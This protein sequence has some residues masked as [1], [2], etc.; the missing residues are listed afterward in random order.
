MISEIGEGGMGRVYKALDRN[1]GRL[2]AVK[3]LR[4]PDPFE[5]SR[6]RG[7]AEMI[8]LLDHPNIVKIFAIDTTPDCRP[9]IALEFAEGG[10]LDRE[11]NAQPLEPR[12]AAEM[13]EILARAIH[14]AHEKGVIHRDLKPANVLRGKDGVLKITDFG[15]AKQLEVSSGMTPSGAVMG[16][17]SYMAP[18]QAEGKV[19]QLGPPTDVYG[20]GAI[21]YEML[22][23]RP[24][25]RGVN[26]VD[27]LEQVRWAE[28]ASP[29][30]FVP[31]LHRDLA[32]ICLKCLRKTP[33]QRYATA[34]ALAEDLRHWLNGETIVARSAPS[35][36][37]AWR[38]IKRRPWQ[39][40]TTVATAFVAGLLVFGAIYFHNRQQ[41]EEYE[42]TLREQETSAQTERNELEKAAREKLDQVQNQ[43]VARLRERNE[44]ALLALEGI[45]DMILKGNL[46]N[47]KELNPLKAGLFKYYKEL[48]KQLK[49]E[50][51]DKKKLAQAWVE[52]GTMIHETGSKENA[53]EA[54]K[55]AVELYQALAENTP[56]DRFKQ[57]EALLK[58]GRVSYER[59]LDREAETACTTV[60]TLLNVSQPDMDKVRAGYLADMWHLRGELDARKRRLSDA[61]NDYNRAINLRLTSA[62]EYHTMS[63]P[64]LV[65]LGKKSPAK[66]KIAVAHLRGLARG[67]GYLG[68][69]LLDERRLVEADKAYWDSQRIRQR[70]V[71]AITLAPRAEGLASRDV[72]TEKDLREAKLQLSR[73]WGNFTQ[74]QTYCRAIATAKHFAETSL[75]LRKEI[76][77]ANPSNIE[78][79]RD[80]CDNLNTIAALL[81]L[82]GDDDGVE[83]MLLESRN[84]PQ[85]TSD[86]ANPWT[87]EALGTVAKSH[88]LLA[89]FYAKNR[90]P[91]KAREE[92]R[93]ALT[94]LESLAK[95]NPSNPGAAF[96]RAVAYALSAELGDPS[97]ASA[98]YQKSL[99]SFELAVRN[100]Y[101]ERHPEDIRAMRAFEKLKANETFEKLL[102]DLRAA[103]K[104]VSQGSLKTPAA[105]PA[106]G[107]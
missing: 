75:K 60:E 59:N 92:L 38:Q 8:A 81:M 49:H 102:G 45:R 1:L 94:H 69:V 15:L 98:E 66:L 95:L 63:V 64:Q 65:E 70:I 99:A 73:G 41:K 27:T 29:S 9:Y 61:I 80:V 87:A 7:E 39:A 56:E 96:D 68:D 30:Q 18:E 58:F 107:Q 67:Y 53:W 57:V 100:H 26:L 93:I 21:L 35:W 3:V 28:P 91:E 101:R 2:V 104:P 13:A 103:R 89:Q 76:S 86:H 74:I 16:T 32:T 10:S 77:S 97:A 12:R 82:L 43:N 55:E 47:T 106:G 48:N 40:A 36:E 24:P 25:F 83:E 42:R 6:F 37:R 23:G 88:V 33:A 50:G 17:P 19:K 78:F 72:L 31:R 85:D 46:P 52:I 14:H 84:M 62:G 51:A 44:A 71:E 90:Q 4:S 5:A 11:L 34:G 79:R 54:Y 105:S 20:L 22:T